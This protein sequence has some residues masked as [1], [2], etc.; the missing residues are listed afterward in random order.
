MTDLRNAHGAAYCELFR[1]ADGFPKKASKALARVKAEIKDNSA[2][3]EFRNLPLG[4]Y[5]VAAFHDE[6]GN[7]RLDSSFLGIPKEGVGT[8]NDATGHWGAP[9]FDKAKF[10]VDGEEKRIAIHIRYSGAVPKGSVV[11]N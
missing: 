9:S 2:D 4:T 3:C 6:N 7:G 8:S 1:N 10:V 11:G 5:A